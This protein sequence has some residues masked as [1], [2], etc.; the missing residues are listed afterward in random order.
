MKL[1]EDNVVVENTSYTRAFVWKESTTLTQKTYLILPSTDK[2]LIKE[3]SLYL[4][5]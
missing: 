5:R 1:G 3:I 2:S 4:D